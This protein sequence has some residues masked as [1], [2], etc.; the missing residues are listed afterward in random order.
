MEYPILGLSAQTEDALLYIFI[1]LNLVVELLVGAL[2]VISGMQL[3]KLK[4]RNCAI[5]FFYILAIP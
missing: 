2:G 5:Q 3:C 1:S 4:Q